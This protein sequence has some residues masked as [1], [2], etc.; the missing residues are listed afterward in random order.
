MV[1][2]SPRLDRDPFAPPAL[3]FSRSVP[4]SIQARLGS[5][6]ER[7]AW[8]DIAWTWELGECIEALNPDDLTPE[9]RARIEAMTVQLFPGPIRIESECDPD[10]PDDKWFVV[11]V[12][13]SGDFQSI[14][15][16]EL[17]WHDKLWELIGRPSGMTFRL[18]VVPK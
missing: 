10:F 18:C 8:G 9:N 2:L 7:N 13:A 14:L 16:D 5:S 1:A 15:D 3:Q 11:E 12:Q 17:A 4:A 6:R